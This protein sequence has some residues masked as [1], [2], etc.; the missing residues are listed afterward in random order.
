MLSILVVGLHLFND[1][2]RPSKR[3][4]SPI[5]VVFSHSCSW[6]MNELPY[7]VVLSSYGDQFNT[8][9]L[10]VRD[11]FKRWDL[12]DVWIFMSDRKSTFS[13]K[14]Y[15][16]GLGNRLKRGSSMHHCVHHGSKVTMVASIWGT[17][18]Q[19]MWLCGLIMQGWTIPSRVIVTSPVLDRHWIFS[20]EHDTD[21]K[22]FRSLL[23]TDTSYLIFESP[24]VCRNWPVASTLHCEHLPVGVCHDQ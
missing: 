22:K 11:W 14:S 1:D 3:I 8:W 12:Y 6:Y 16:A 5:H 2:T 13:L 10:S 18:E 9:I 20:G 24:A 4:N 17:P 7:P 21:F 19:D 15:Y 23:Y